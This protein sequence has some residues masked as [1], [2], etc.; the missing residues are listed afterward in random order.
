MKI[1]L[2]VNGVRRDLEVPPLKRLL[3]VLREDLGLVGAKEGCGE[4]ECG[5]CAV[6][7]DGRLVNSCLLPAYRAH[8]RVVRT[9]EGLGTPESP[10]P[11]QSAFVVEGAVQCGYC[12]PGLVMASR[13]LL[14]EEASPTRPRIREALAGNLCRCTGYERIIRAVER[15]GQTPARVCGTEPSP[16]PASEPEASPGDEV[17]VHVPGSLREACEM[18]GRGGVTVIGGATDLGVLLHEEIVAPRAVLD[19]SRVAEL[20]GVRREEGALV[21]GAATTY[22]DLLRDPDVARD[23]PCLHAA[24]RTVGAPA[25]QSLGT[26]GGNL[27]NGS[28]GADAVPPLLALGARIRLMSGAGGRE[29]AADAFFTGYRATV[30]RPDELVAAIIVPLPAAGTRQSFRKAGTRRAQA[31]AKVN[32]AACARVQDGALRDVRLAAGSVGPTVLLL[33]RAM[34]ALEGG[35]VADL[36]RLAGAVAAAARDEVVPIDDVRSTADYRRAVTGN[37][38]ARFVLSLGEAPFL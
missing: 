34:A 36:E 33:R 11:V 5:A 13:A 21:I 16:D 26:L 1:S 2:W 9:I 25:I 38:V 32:L 35:R 20:H 6:I 29:V 14:D 23:L 37:L 12:I 31:I 30:R 27:V 3:D 7:L 28:P 4:G 17:V 22:A 18:L 19:L 8:G 10:D 24:V 15:A